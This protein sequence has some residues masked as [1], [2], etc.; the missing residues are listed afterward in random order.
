[1]QDMNRRERRSEHGQVGFYGPVQRAAGVLAVSG[2]A[3]LA[4][5][6]AKAPCEEMVPLS[7]DSSVTTQPITSPDGGRTVY[8]TAFTVGDQVTVTLSTAILGGE[9]LQREMLTDSP[10]S[11]LQYPIDDAHTLT[12]RVEGDA[13]RSSCS[14]K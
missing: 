11:R 14:D 4:S 10:D 13:V 8:A 1:M 12:L 2:V 6:C 7:S 5:S 3:L 9:M